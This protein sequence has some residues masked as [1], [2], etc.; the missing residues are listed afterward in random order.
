[1]NAIKRTSR[2][3]SQSEK[4]VKILSEMSAQETMNVPCP[5]GTTDPVHRRS[6]HLPSYSTMVQ[7]RHKG[8]Y[9]KK[10]R[11]YL[12]HELHDGL[13]GT[14]HNVLLAASRRASRRVEDCA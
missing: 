11:A 13:D 9:E 8:A 4:R 3:V 7:I 2:P 5:S 14:V 6:S 1:M 12:E 10:S